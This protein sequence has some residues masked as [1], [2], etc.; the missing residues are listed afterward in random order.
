MEVKI[1]AFCN[2]DVVVKCQYCWGSAFQQTQLNS[3]GC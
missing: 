1:K 2:T 3:L